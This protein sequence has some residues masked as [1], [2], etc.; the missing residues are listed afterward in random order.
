VRCVV[1][2]VRGASVSVHGEEVARIGAGLLALLGVAAGDGAV[3]VAWM[4][5]KVAGLRVF[6]DGAGKMNRSL[7]DV[8]GALLVVSQFT[9]LGDCRA[10]RR[11]S[12]TGAAPPAEGE[13]LYGEF[14]A[15][16]ARVAGV[17]VQCGRFGA[18]MLV[19]LEN[20]GPVTLIL[21][22]RAAGTLEP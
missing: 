16:A 12:F 11:P 5:R 22:S 1:Q 2:R 6:D 15:E 17:P 19:A 20:D 13:R 9:L 7:A 3:D 21:D 4:A 8:G 18:D 14:L 10:G